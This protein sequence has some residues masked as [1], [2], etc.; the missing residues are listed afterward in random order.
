MSLR[1][2]EINAMKNFIAGWYLED[3]A[4]CDALIRY[5]RD[6]PAK[7]QG[8]MSGGGGGRVDKASKD[9]VDVT[10]PPSEL[11]SAYIAALHEVA[12]AYV[13]Q[14]PW[15]ARLVPWGVV[16]PIGIQH[17][18][19]GG[20]YKVW[21]FERDNTSDQ[22]ARRHLAFM[23]Y[24]NDVAAGGGTE[25]FHQELTFR[26]EKGLTLV[27]PAEWNFTHRGVV[28]HAEEKYIVTGWFSTYTREQ[29]ERLGR[30]FGGAQG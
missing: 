19:P 21:H 9:S 23:T 24:L 16:E 1:S 3:V 12:K 17:Y 5:H 14:Y 8:V 27:W 28:A 29:Y 30:R 15:S 7:R 18:E 6:S 22:I 25:F 20:G 13:E 4:I 26:A 2:H 11:A 10:L